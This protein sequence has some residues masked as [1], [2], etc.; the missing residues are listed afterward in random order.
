MSGIKHLSVELAKLTAVLASA[1]FWIFWG[2]LQI[3]GITESR[4]LGLILMAEF[5]SAAAI[6]GV[7]ALEVRGF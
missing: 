7:L 5:Y 4:F 3:I 6:L 1:W 2:D